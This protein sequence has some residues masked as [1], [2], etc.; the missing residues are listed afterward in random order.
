MAQ[1]TQIGTYRT[2]RRVG[3]QR[4]MATGGWTSYTEGDEP[5]AGYAAYDKEGRTWRIPAPDEEHAT[6]EVAADSPEGG[7]ILG[8]ANALAAEAGLQDDAD[9][10]QGDDGPFVPHIETEDDDELDDP[11]AGL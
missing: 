5:P 3:D 10:D 6:K 11:F 8:Q 7:A 1:Q 4:M 2:A 9:D